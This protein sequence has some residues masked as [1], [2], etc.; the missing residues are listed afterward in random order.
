MLVEFF[1]KIFRTDLAEKQV[2]AMKA[3]DE[4]AV[5][6][7]L[8]N[9]WLLMAPVSFCFNIFLIAKYEYVSSYR[10]R[11]KSKMLFTYMKN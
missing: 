7:M 5:L 11:Q 10:V 2:K 4:D 3:V 8:A 9:A 6:T 1:L